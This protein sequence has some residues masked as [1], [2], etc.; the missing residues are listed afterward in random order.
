MHSQNGARASDGVV[1]NAL[2][3]AAVLFEVS[4]ENLIYVQ[5]G[6][7]LRGVPELRLELRDLARIS[8]LFGDGPLRDSLT[9]L[10]VSRRASP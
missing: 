4:P 1:Q 6:V 5:G 8:I 9:G 10:S 2:H 3:L 7:E